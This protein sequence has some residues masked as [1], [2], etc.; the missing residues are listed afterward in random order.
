MISTLGAEL[1]HF[2]ML[3]DSDVQREVYSGEIHP[4]AQQL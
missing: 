4:E 3:F 1:V 2:N